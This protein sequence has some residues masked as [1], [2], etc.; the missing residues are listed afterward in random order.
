[1]ENQGSC[2]DSYKGCSRRYRPLSVLRPTSGLRGPCAI[3]GTTW[4]E[5][6]ALARQAARGKRLGA[7]SFACGFPGC[8]RKFH[9][10]RKLAPHFAAHH[11]LVPV[12]AEPLPQDSSLPADLRYPAFFFTREL[13]IPPEV[14][15]NTGS[16]A[17]LTTFPEARPVPAKDLTEPL[18]GTFT[19]SLWLHEGFD[20]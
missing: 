17:R 20:Y 14:A 7:K 16:V 3:S 19:S 11:A 5:I 15:A 6:E 1:M 18:E 12:P 8:G 13:P 4:R 10:V 2:S 9:N